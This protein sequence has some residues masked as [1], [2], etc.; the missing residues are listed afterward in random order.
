VSLPRRPLGFLLRASSLPDYH[1]DGFLADAALTYEVTRGALTDKE[2]AN[3]STLA[4]LILYTSS[5]RLALSNRGRYS[6][7]ICLATKYEGDRRVGGRRSRWWRRLWNSRLL[8]IQRHSSRFGR[9]NLGSYPL[10]PALAA[11]PRNIRAPI[12]SSD[13]AS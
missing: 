3:S 1:C 10:M 6:A 2:V 4:L 12:I 7:W 5:F 8:V 11:R 13:Q 9:P